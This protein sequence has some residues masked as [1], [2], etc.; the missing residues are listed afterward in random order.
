MSEMNRR[1]FIKKSVV[2]VAVGTTSLCALISCATF[3]KVGSD[4]FANPDAL[5]IKHNQ[6]RIDLSKEPMLSKVGGSI[7]IK[8]EAV[9]EGII[10]ACV[11]ENRL[12]IASLRCTHRGVEVE[13]DP[14]NK[15]FECAS[16]GSS[17]YTLDGK[18]VSGPAKHPLKN[19]QASVEDGI[20]I[21]E[22]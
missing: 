22:L 3:T 5:N 18:N 10:I 9:P 12:E 8:N 1:D 15:N 2:T 4:K 21:I 20:L 13:Y 17:K 11:E 19:Y 7:K 16:L 6:L 14:K